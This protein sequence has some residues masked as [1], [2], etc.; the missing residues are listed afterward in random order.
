MENEK[1]KKTIKLQKTG[2]SMEY[3]YICSIGKEV[4]CIAGGEI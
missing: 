2:I 1:E 4:S 3:G